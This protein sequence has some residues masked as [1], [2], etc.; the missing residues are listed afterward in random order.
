MKKKQGRFTVISFFITLLV[1]IGIFLYQNYKSI[2]KLSAI[3]LNNVAVFRKT[4]DVDNISVSYKDKSINTL[5]KYSFK[6]VNDGNRPITKL[7]IFKPIQMQFNRYDNVFNVNVDSTK[8]N[9]IN[10]YVD[11]N[12]TVATIGFDLL[13]PNDEIYISVISEGDVSNNKITSRISNIKEIYRKEI[14]ESNDKKPTIYSISWLISVILVLMLYNQVV[15][16]VRIVKIRKE[17]LLKIDAIQEGI[18]KK[19]LREIIVDLSTISRQERAEIIRYIN[20]TRGAIEGNKYNA[21]I[22]YIKAKLDSIG[23]TVGWLVIT[24]F[25]LLYVAWVIIVINIMTKI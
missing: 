24:T 20:I 9:N 13:N 19:D 21:I 12:D 6:I 17:D 10:Y 25:F 1:T 4:M 15:S 18:E 16:I 8:P 3:E 2:Y 14:T 11:Y 23:S 22:K 7:D 5:R